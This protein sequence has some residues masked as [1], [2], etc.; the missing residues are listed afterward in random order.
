ML[1]ELRNPG[2]P[3]AVRRWI[4]EPV[5]WLVIQAPNQG[6]DSA[7]LEAKLGPGEQEAILLA[8]EVNADEMIIDELRGRREATR[9]QIRV[10]GTVGVLRVAAK[11]GLLDLRDA[12]ERLRRTN[13]RIHKDFLDRL[14]REEV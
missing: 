4:S 10:T 3:E 11:N 7:L 8:Q 6:P 12:L 13:F 2:A 1:G 9:R 14:I 5:P